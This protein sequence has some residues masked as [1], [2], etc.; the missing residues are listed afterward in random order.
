MVDR[1]LLI[2]A[3]RRQFTALLE[4]TAGKEACP[5]THS[6][7]VRP[8][9]TFVIL[10]PVKN[11]KR[12]GLDF[13]AE[14][15]RAGAARL[16]CT[17][18]QAEEIASLPPACGESPEIILVEDSREALGEL[19]RAY[20]D[21]ADPRRLLLGITGTNGKTT[22]AYLL[23][24][25][26]SGLGRKTGVLGTINYRWPGVSRPSPLTTPDCLELHEMF[27][28]MRRAGVEAAIMEASSH[29]LEQRR[30]AGLDFQ[31]ALFTNL[32]QDHLDYHLDMENYYQA[33]ASLFR[34]ISG[35]NKPGPQTA[36]LRAVNADDA[37][38][39]RL[40]VEC[41]GLPGLNIAY[42][43]TRRL[44][45]GCEFLHGAILSR[46]SEGLLLRQ[47][48]R[49][50][51]WE[52]RSP[53]LGDFNAVNLLGVQALALGLGMDVEN[54]KL[55]E[56]FGGVPG[57]LERIANDR[58]VHVF[59]DYAHT[60]DALENVLRALRSAGFKRIVTVFGCGGNRDKSKRPLMGRAVCAHSDVAVLTSDNPRLE[61]PLEI[62]RDV[63]PGMQGRDFHLAED[64][65][66]AT[67]L[68]V[69]L[70][71][72]GD[73][74]LVAGKGHEDYQIVGETRKYYSDQAVLR[75]LLGAKA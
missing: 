73:A 41:S 72:R 47:N 45:P 60:P 23:E 58:G 52:L 55:L 21:S 16:V 69:K 40:L 64:R 37:G 56:K 57:R 2:A 46:G 67:A 10:P 11:G 70:L 59:V 22:S 28:E 35:G 31:A 12:S 3:G 50:L 1:E 71:R 5:R 74:L 27:G 8:G 6:G 61:D 7:R 4:L 32:T 49:E 62:M 18:E 51:E 48:F 65:R 13:A 24:A 54:L 25:L 42:G 20:Y 15:V 9:D 75:E 44:V 68:G 34:R 30:T 39:R 14:A 26:F 66:E 29:A 53:L 43:L 19:A 36:P 33:K 17:P 38:G 63:L